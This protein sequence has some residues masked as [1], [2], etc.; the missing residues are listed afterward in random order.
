MKA[1]VA[2]LIA[3]GLLMTG[4]GNGESPQAAEQPEDTAPPVI[5]PYEPAIDPADFVEGVDNPYFPLEPGT[6]RVYEGGTKDEDEVVTVTVT[7]KTKVVMGV[8][9]V[10]VKD[11]EE[12]DGELVEETYDWFAQDRHGNVWYFGEDTKEFEDG[13]VDS[14]GSWEAGVDGALPGIIMLADPDVGE[15][16]RQEFY[17]GEAEDMGQILKLGQ[18]LAV[19]YGSFEDV[20]VTKDWTP[21]EPSA[22]ERKYY[23]PGVGPIREEGLKGDKAVLEL[24][25]VG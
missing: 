3:G 4:C 21:L 23:A 14:A 7:R 15:R 25:S 1:L 12:I 5:S 9:C 20:L 18:S 22:L 11:I 13:K 17:E 16:Y 24:V 6:T 2:S 19:P 10:V 8:E